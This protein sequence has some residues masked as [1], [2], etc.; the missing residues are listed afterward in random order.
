MALDQ[1]IVSILS[2]LEGSG[3]SRLTPVRPLHGETDEDQ[4]YDIIGEIRGAILPRRLV[5]H[6]EGG[7]QL[8]LIAGSGRLYRVD[9]VLP[10][11]L[12]QGAISS[13]MSRESR[14]EAVVEAISAFAQLDGMLQLEPLFLDEDMAAEEVGFTSDEL[15]DWVAEKGVS[16][17]RTP[18]HAQLVLGLNGEVIDQVGDVSLFPSQDI[19][20]KLLLESAQWREDF[21]VMT[22]T[23]SCVV[24]PKI[25]DQEHTLAIYLTLDAI[26]IQVYAGSDISQVAKAWNEA[27]NSS[28]E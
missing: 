18:L 12:P 4:A 10:S 26:T 24:V 20:N 22:G 23:P 8:V 1:E 13:T 6:K 28:E 15:Y 14:V 7:A 19:I 5:F 27:L 17:R 9:K 21:S 25:S 11:D 2:S 3:T 16:A